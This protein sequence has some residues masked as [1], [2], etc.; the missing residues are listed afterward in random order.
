PNSLIEEQLARLI[1]KIESSDAR[2]GQLDKIER[3]L[4]EL[5]LQ[6][7]R[8]AAAPAAGEGAHLPELDTLKRDVQRNQDSIEA[9]NGRPGQAVVRLS[10]IETELRCAPTLSQPSEPPS[11]PVADTRAPV[12]QANEVQLQAMQVLDATPVA[13]P[14]A[15]ASHASYARASDRVP[16]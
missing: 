14:P 2:F 10:S 16:I 15:L 13:P 6:I 5:L 8:Q 7:D 11:G 1:E 3:A 9:V 4:A 12:A